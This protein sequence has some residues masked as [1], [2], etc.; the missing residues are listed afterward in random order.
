MLSQP[1]FSDKSLIK[2]FYN[3]LFNCFC[4][5]LEIN[6]QELVNQCY[7]GIVSSPN[8]IKTFCIVAPNIN[9]AEKLADQVDIILQK[10][11]NLM[12]GI[13]QT[14]I[15]FVPPQQQNIISNSTL[16]TINTLH[17]QK[18]FPKFMMG[19]IF[20]NPFEFETLIE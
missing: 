1:N 4:N 17:H 16:E 6:N 11:A 7:L 9:I 14:A 18:F 10:V 19:K 3:A 13:E 8:Q 5:S 12:P 15:C 20:V 2:S